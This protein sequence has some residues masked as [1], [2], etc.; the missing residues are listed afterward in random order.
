M[1]NLNNLIDR[2][3]IYMSAL[4]DFTDPVVQY[5]KYGLCYYFSTYFGINVYERV[6]FNNTFPELFSLR[7]K[8]YDLYWFCENDTASRRELLVKAIEIIE[9]KINRHG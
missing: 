7:P 9:D 1:E 3:F 4:E 6:D 2:M 8:Q 5:S